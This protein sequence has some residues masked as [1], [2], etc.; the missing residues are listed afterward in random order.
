V[1]CFLPRARAS[2]AIFGARAAVLKTAVARRWSACGCGLPAAP[3]RACKGARAALV[4]QARCHGL[5]EK[6]ARTCAPRNTFFP[7]QSQMGRCQAPGCT[8][9]HQDSRHFYLRDGD[10]IRVNCAHKDELLADGWIRDMQAKADLAVYQAAKFVELKADDDAYKSR[11]EKK[12]SAQAAAREEA[13]LVPSPCPL[14]G[15]VMQC[16]RMCE[17]THFPDR[18]SK[19]RH[20]A[21]CHYRMGEVGC[22]ACGT[23]L[24]DK[25][26]LR[27]HIRGC[28]MFLSDDERKDAIEASYDKA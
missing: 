2:R 24:G 1:P 10:R 23:K 14:I 7:T 11:Q 27:A 5:G 13:L 8:S 22:V 20:V 21:N 3:A 18:V 9:A 26:A 15:K 4:G 19:Y 28:H 25:S 6:I 12:I 17:R 16:G